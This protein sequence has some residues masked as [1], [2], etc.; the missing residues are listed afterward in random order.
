MF[1]GVRCAWRKTCGSRRST[2]LFPPVA[3]GQRFVRVPR[4]S[5]KYPTKGGALA[6]ANLFIPDGSSSSMDKVSVLDVV[7]LFRL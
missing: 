6:G 5:P 7:G 3:V 1:V 4:S 2:R